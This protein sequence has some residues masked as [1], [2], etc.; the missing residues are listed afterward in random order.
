MIRSWFKEIAPNK[1]EKNPI[2]EC[3]LQFITVFLP[4]YAQDQ[5]PPIAF[6]SLLFFK[7]QQERFFALQKSNSLFF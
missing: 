2:F 7:E 5:I 4:L 3:F 6:R 1:L